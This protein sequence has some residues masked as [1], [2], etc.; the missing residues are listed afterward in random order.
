MIQFLSDTILCDDPRVTCKYGHRIYS[1]RTKD[2]P[3]DPWPRYVTGHG[4]HQCS[5]RPA[6]SPPDK[7]S[8]IFHIRGGKV[9]EIW[10]ADDV[11]PS[12]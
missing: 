6:H 9:V 2:T 8:F 12:W 1:L 11:I 3:P 5:S 10:R 4:V 7:L